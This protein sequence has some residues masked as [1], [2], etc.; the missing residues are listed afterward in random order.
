M[1]I[2]GGLLLTQTAVNIRCSHYKSMFRCM[3]IPMM[4]LAL[5][6]FNTKCTIMAFQPRPQRTAR[7]T[8]LRFQYDEVRVGVAVLENNMNYMGKRLERI[9][10][11]LK[12]VKN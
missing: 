11:E 9:E 1:N 4:L 5:T 3:R 6:A 2:L 12:E 8:T 10:L 7:M